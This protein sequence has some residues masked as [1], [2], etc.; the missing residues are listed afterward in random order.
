M[1][2]EDINNIEQLLGR[3]KVEEAK[4]EEPVS[5]EQSPEESLDE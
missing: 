5:D 1:I 4:E 3:I 2:T